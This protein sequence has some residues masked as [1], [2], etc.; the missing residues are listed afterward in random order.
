MCAPGWSRRPIPE[1][2]WWVSGR[3]RPLGGASSSQ[4]RRRWEAKGKLVGWVCR[5]LVR[6]LSLMRPRGIGG[7]EPVFVGRGRELAD[8]QRAYGRVVGSRPT[9]AGHCRR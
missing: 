3:W 9:A 1:K 8:L 6:A 2:S 4:S 7:L 5:K